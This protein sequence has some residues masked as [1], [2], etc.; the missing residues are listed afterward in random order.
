M[1]MMLNHQLLAA[2]NKL[3]IAQAIGDNIMWEQAMHAMRGIFIAAKNTE[4]RMLEGY[5]NPLSNLL[6]EDVVCNYEIYGDLIIAD[7]DLLLGHAK[8]NTEIINH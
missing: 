8:I 3:V 1:V 6:I 2:Q 5:A 4:D 7:G